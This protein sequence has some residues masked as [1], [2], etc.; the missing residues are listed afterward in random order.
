MAKE[1]DE[2]RVREE[3]DGLDMG[4]DSV[5]GSRADR[6]RQEVHPLMRPLAWIVIGAALIVAALSL[7]GCATVAGAAGK[8][9]Q[10]VTSADIDAAIALA[11]QSNDADGLACW[12]AVKAAMPAGADGVQVEIKGVASAWQAGRNLRRSVD[13]GINPE[14]HRACA[15][16]VVD[17]E[18]TAGKLGLRIGA[19]VK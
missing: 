11:Q 10:L 16:L 4:G 14:V 5:P 2:L 1:N 19:V 7:H 6:L 17:A 9:L 8:N 12:M 15:V 18:Q 13:A 3:F